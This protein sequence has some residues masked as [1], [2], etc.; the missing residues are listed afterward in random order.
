MNAVEESRYLL[1]LRDEE[2]QLMISLPTWERA[3]EFLNTCTREAS[4]DLG[5][6]IDMPAIL[7]GPCGSID[8]HWKSSQYEMLINI[9]AD[10]G[11][12][13]SYFGDDS[14]GNSVK[15]TIVSGDNK[16]LLLWLATRM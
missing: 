4:N 8:L 2:D 15:G 16:G 10:Q 9:P 1:T 6:Q 5:G 7:P 13:A 12:P 14:D 3:I 11:V